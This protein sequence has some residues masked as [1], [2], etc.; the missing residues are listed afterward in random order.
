MGLHPLRLPEVMHNYDFCANRLSVV[1]ARSRS[2]SDYVQYRV[3]PSWPPILI[4]DSLVQYRAGSELE[5]LAPPARLRRDYSVFL[6]VS[7]RMSTD[8]LLVCGSASPSRIWPL[9]LQGKVLLQNAHL[10]LFCATAPHFLPAVP[11]FFP[12]WTL[13]QRFC[14]H[15]VAAVSSCR[16]SCRES[17][18]R[19]SVNP[20]RATT[21]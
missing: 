17:P 14:W 2:R 12:V 5:Q 16:S 4:S 18:R 9:S 6:S 8:L 1:R 19:L 3:A 10:S 7:L 15:R 13:A 20:L 11:V 21:A